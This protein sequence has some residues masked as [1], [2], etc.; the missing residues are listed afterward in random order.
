MRISFIEFKRLFLG[1]GITRIP[2]SM[3]IANDDERTEEGREWEGGTTQLF[4]VEGGC[5]E[6]GIVGGSSGERIG[7]G[8]VNWGPTSTD[9]LYI[10]LRIKT[11]RDS[12]RN[13]V[14][15]ITHLSWIHYPLSFSLCLSLFLS[16]ITPTYIHHSNFSSLP[17][18]H[19][20]NS[21]LCR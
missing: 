17:C 12:K 19:P 7:E 6:G 11:R 9:S 5:H 1:N 21:P 8:V 18:C 4:R 14:S 20:F 2:S 10:F 15:L 3:S 16:T 13:N